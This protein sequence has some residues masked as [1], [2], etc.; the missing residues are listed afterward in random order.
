MRAHG[1]I[2]VVRNR[3]SGA[4]I[5]LPSPV[6]HA[7]QMADRRWRVRVDR[8]AYLTALLISPLVLAA[9]AVHAACNPRAFIR[10][11]G[12]EAIDI[13][14][15][16]GSSL[17]AREAAFRTLLRN[18]FDLN[19]I[20]RFVLARHWRTA[21][22]EQREEFVEVF[23][24]YIVK[25]YSVRFG[26]YAGETLVVESERPGGTNNVVVRTRI[27]RPS[28]PPI[29][30]D[31]RVRTSGPKCQIIDVVVEGISMAITH[32][33]EIE[34]VIGRDGMNGAIAVLRARTGKAPAAAPG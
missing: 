29:S 15:R 7:M 9:G 21:S 25:T 28:G 11:L 8:R 2:A 27:D 13:L 4:P 5:R 1:G 32:R 19:F 22:P 18:A 30:A 34:A 3:E 6:P 14:R 10:H 17:E 20:A 23:G 26:G 24:D 33:D 12:D 16:T 31:W